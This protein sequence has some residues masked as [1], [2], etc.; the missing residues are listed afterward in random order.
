MGAYASE[1]IKQQLGLGFSNKEILMNPAL[2]WGGQLT[3]WSAA[4]GLSSPMSGLKNVLIQIPRS[5]AIYG[6][7]N[8]MRAIA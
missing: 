6:T 2:R 1:T 8:T 3:N 7:R 5:V 4:A